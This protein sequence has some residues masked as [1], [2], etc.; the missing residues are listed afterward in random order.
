[1]MAVCFRFLCNGHKHGVEIACV[2]APLITRL[3]PTQTATPT[4]NRISLIWW[5]CTYYIYHHQ[6]LDAV[7]R[8]TNGSTTIGSRTLNF[9]RVRTNSWFRPITWFASLSFSLKFL[10]ISVG[11]LLNL[12]LEN[13]I[14]QFW[15]DFRKTHR[16]C[17]S[18]SDCIFNGNQTHHIK[19]AY[20]FLSL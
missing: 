8:S 10:P 1:M 16:K 17:S 12:F 3:K 2:R 5:Y 11:R 20:F 13:F 4:H 14:T 9:Q 7:Q 18:V 6:R 15:L 19:S